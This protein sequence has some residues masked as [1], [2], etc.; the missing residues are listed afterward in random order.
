MLR[1]LSSKPFKLTFS[2]F[3]KFS[4]SE[5]FGPDHQKP[6]DIPLLDENIFKK[7]YTKEKRLQEILYDNEI[8]KNPKKYQAKKLNE[9]QKIYGVN[10]SRYLASD[11]REE[12]KGIRG[13]TAYIFK[14]LSDEKHP[15][16]YRFHD[17]VDYS[18]NN[19]NE[20][21]IRKLHSL[22][23]LQIKDV[24]SYGI[25]FEYIPRSEAEHES[26]YKESYPQIKNYAAELKPNEILVHNLPLDTHIN[27]L[28]EFLEKYGK[29]K[30]IKIYYC[31]LNL[32]AFAKV[33]FEKNDS[34]ITV[35]Q[36]VHWKT[37][38][39]SLLSIKTSQDGDYEDSWNRTLCV[40]NIPHDMSEI[41]S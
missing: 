38:K 4:T 5:Y 1:Y 37:W 23:Y 18:V 11:L 10:Y 21:I 6:L 27:D 7:L 39:N 19:E 9:K 17:D 13:K 26:L 20:N 25:D 15:N 40:M 2:H 34:V 24:G 29:I 8:V 12:I 36:E 35:L 22:N 33:S 3:P 14:N 30:D 28:I 31:V 41:V 16:N 32:P